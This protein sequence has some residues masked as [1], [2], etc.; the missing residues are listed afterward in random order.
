MKPKDSH[1]QWNCC[2][3]DEPTLRKI[4]VVKCKHQNGFISLHTSSL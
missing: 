3:C 1:I 2:T 4:C